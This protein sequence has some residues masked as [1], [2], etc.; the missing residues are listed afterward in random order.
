[1]LGAVFLFYTVLS[2]F[3][4]ASI[5]DDREPT[6]IPAVTLVVFGTASIVCIALHV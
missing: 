2:L 1:M 3:W 4:L 6:K 5:A